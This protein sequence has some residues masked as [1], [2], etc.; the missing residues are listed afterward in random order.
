M[1]LIFRP[2]KV[3]DHVKVAGV[4]GVI[5][6]IDLF[7]S[8]FKSPD[9]RRLIVPNNAIF[10]ATI[11]NVTHFPERRVD[12]NLT[13]PY[14]ADLD[15]TRAALEKVAGL[16]AGVLPEPAPQVFLAGLGTGTVQWQLR[17]WCARE[18][19]WDVY[20]AAIRE[21]KR[22]LDATRVETAASS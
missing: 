10:G 14:E 7:T 13:S 21:A 3:G 12:I 17:L 16:V 20:Q 8:E 18:D 1:L 19:Y 5:E 15:A 6:A 9:N 4:E 22:Q 2:F 11:D